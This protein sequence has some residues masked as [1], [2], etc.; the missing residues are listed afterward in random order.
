[1]RTWRARQ[2]FFVQTSVSHRRAVPAADNTLEAARV[3][4]RI[5]LHVASTARCGTINKPGVQVQNRLPRIAWPIFSII[6]IHHLIPYRCPQTP[7][8]QPIHR[9]QHLPNSLCSQPN[10]HPRDLSPS[11]NSPMVL[12]PRRMGC[13]ART[14]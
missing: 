12:H 10:F 13:R 1:M 7:H 2:S 3:C 6:P 11:P 5:V 8:Q 14:K 9:R 4:G